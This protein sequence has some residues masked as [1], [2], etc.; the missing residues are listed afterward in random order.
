M[1]RLPYVSWRSFSG[2]HT[3]ILSSYW[4]YGL[5]YQ[6]HSVQDWSIGTESYP[7]FPIYT[8]L[9]TGEHF[10]CHLLA[11]WFAELFFDPEDGDDTF[12]LN[13]KKQGTT[14]R[15]TLRH[16]P[17][18]ETLHNHRCENLKSYNNKQDYWVFGL[19]TSSGVLETK[20]NTAFRKQIQFPK[21]VLFSVYNFVRCSKSKKSSNSECYTS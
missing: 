3:P 6:F 15:T 10:A 20:I 13:V 11:R 21:R 12:L 18:D 2:P 16:I 4:S 19:C 7:L 1:P 5:V 8:G 14:L 9:P 17:E